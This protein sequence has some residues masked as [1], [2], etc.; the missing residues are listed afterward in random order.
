MQALTRTRWVVRRRTAVLSLNAA[1]S[2]WLVPSSTATAGEPPVAAT[3]AAPAANADAGWEQISAHDGITVLMKDLAGT[4]TISL[5]AHAV[6]A[7]SVDDIFTVMRDNK[8]AAEWMPMI[9]ERRDLEPLG[10]HQ[11]IE[12]THI[13]MPWPLTDRYFVNR[14]RMERLAGGSMRLSV[15]SEAEPKL[16]DK[17][18]VLG[19]LLYSEFLLTPQGAGTHMT[20]EVNTDPRG[21]I[22]KWLVNM[23][24]KS[25][26]RDFFTGLQTQLAKRGLL[27]T[28]R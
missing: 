6:L 28:G 7:A 11:R 13:R 4:P 12:Y 3:A 16:V 2:C 9:A 20:L 17:D 1:L 23:A 10:D 26:P 15:K 25:W 14:A 22:P 5:R 19:K 24:Q 18:K 27:K 8:T 21:A